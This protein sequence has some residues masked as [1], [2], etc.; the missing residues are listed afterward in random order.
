MKFYVNTSE[1]RV[2]NGEV[3]ITTGSHLVEA[4]SELEARILFKKFPNERI[5]SV[6]KEE[7]VVKKKVKN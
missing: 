1:R 5:E 2:E 6:I 7:E 4:S 3:I